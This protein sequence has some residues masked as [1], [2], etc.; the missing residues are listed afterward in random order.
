MPLDISSDGQYLIFTT[1]T[2]PQGFDPDIGYYDFARDTVVMLNYY[3]TESDEWIARISPDGKWLLYNSGFSG[4]NELYVVPFPGPGP[5][6]KISADGAAHGIWAPD[7]SAVYYLENGVESDMWEVKINLDGEFSFEKPNS[8]FSGHYYNSYFNSRSGIFDI[9][10][11]GD[12]FLMLQN[13][14]SEIL[15]SIKVIVNWQQE[16]D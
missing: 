16:L 9:H 2:N 5:R 3:N 6:Y 15:P 14:E 7:M 10:P 13:S 4:Q 8:L 11:D 12:R 1:N